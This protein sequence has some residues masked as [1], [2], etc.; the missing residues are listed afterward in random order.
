M[1]HILASNFYNNNFRMVLEMTIENK[2]RQPLFTQGNRYAEQPHLNEGKTKSRTL[3]VV[4]KM[5]G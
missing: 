5:P 2:K 3:G 4:V 1:A